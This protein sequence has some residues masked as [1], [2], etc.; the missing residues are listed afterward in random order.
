MKG[1]LS[2]Q[3]VMRLTFVVFFLNS[4]PVFAQSK[5]FETISNK[6][7]LPQAVEKT[8]NIRKISIIQLDETALRKYLQASPLEFHNGGVTLPLEIPLPNGTSETF[9]MVESPVLSPEQ[10]ALHPE[11]KTYTGNGLKNKKYVV[12]LSLTSSGF[13]AIILNVED[14]AVYFEPY[15]KADRNLYFSYFS[16]DAFIPKNLRHL[17]DGCGAGSLHRANGSVDISS[18]I[19][20]PENAVLNNTG[21]TLRTYRLA[22][23]STAEFTNGHAGADAAAKK[24]A[25]FNDIA[26]YVNRMSAVYRNEI[27]VTFSLVSGESVVYTV[28]GTPYTNSNT[29]TM[30]D[31]C[32]VDLDA[33][34]MTANYDVGHVIGQ[35]TDSGDGVAIAQGCDPTGKAKGA[36]RIGGTPFAQVFFD[37]TLFHEV[38]HQ[39]G[40]NHSYNSSIPVCTTRNAPTSAEPG[41]GATIMSYGFT[42]GN[43]DYFSSTTNGPIL[44]FHTVN[45]SEM[46]TYMASNSGCGTLTPTLNTL[47]V[48]IQPANYNIPKSTPFELTG[49]ATDLN[50]DALT[51]SWE[52]TN[53]GTETP[54]AATLANTAKPPFFRTY[55]P[56]STTSRTFPL[57]SAIIGGTNYEKGDKLPSVAIA[58]TH[59][60]TVRDNRAGGGS[61]VFKDVTVTVDGASGPFLETTN[62]AATYM[63]NSSQ[64]ITWSVNNTTSAPISCANVKISISTDGGTTFPTVLLASTPNDGTETITLPNVATTTA[65][66]KVEAVG[67]VFFDISNAN[68]TITVLLPVELL[69]FQAKAAGKSNQL[70][71]RTTSEKNNYG[72]EVERSVDGQTFYKIGFVKGF[73]TVQTTQHYQMLDLQPLNIT[74]YYRLKQLDTDGAIAYSK[75]V[76]VTN[77]GSKVL[78][79]YPTLV[80]NSI[81]ML[82]TEGVDFAIYNLLGQQVQAGKVSQQIDVS[83]LTQGTYIIKVGEEQAKFMKQ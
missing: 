24:T 6:D 40:M 75:I 61:T 43:D 2:T 52:G 51:Y 72:F 65:R 27:C 4:I 44:V 11:I 63:G 59:R 49:S 10:A 48:V 41:A 34:V 54:D 1:F 69:D 30:L 19:L 79:V 73:G 57:L 39:F 28:P 80:S 68:F 33:N 23:A 36:T 46:V 78:R 25:T 3:R 22:V 74:N 15:S 70:I 38:G 77:K 5:F 42:C 66:I 16:K 53:I 47:P 64:S 7:K 8:Q 67:N 21:A 60:L 31:Q 35:T 32:Q 62:L 12:R 13:N 82:D 9:G 56:S 58:T 45:Y 17:G 18:K 29:G 37:Q 55:D 76:S 83:V 14:D 50:G 20:L 71:W 81:L 26:A